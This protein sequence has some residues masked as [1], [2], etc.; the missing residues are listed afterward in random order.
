MSYL[1]CIIHIAGSVQ[2]F[3]LSCAHFCTCFRSKDFTCPCEEVWHRVEQITGVHQFVQQLFHRKRP[4]SIGAHLANIIVQLVTR[5]RPQE[6]LRILVRFRKALDVVLCLIELIQLV[7]KVGSFD[8]D[9]LLLNTIG[10]ICGYI[11]FVICAAIR[12]RHAG[13]K[14]KNRR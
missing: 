14:T 9:D 7:S 6:L 4:V 10:G 11:L 1:F 2:E 3:R 13:K 5:R 8:V 12:R